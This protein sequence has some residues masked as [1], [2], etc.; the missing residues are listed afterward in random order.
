M[1]I[2]FR[3]GDLFG[4]ESAYAGILE[5]HSLDDDHKPRDDIGSRTIYITADGFIAGSTLCESLED[6]LSVVCEEIRQERDGADKRR[7]NMQIAKRF[8]DSLSD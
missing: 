8:I 1:K 2:Y 3:D 7:I 4:I 5:V 6:A